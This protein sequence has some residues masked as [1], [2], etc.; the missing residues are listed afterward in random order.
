MTAPVVHHVVD[1]KALR[2]RLRMSRPR[3]AARFGLSVGTLRQWELG[4][5]TPDGAARALLTAISRSPETVDMLLDDRQ[6]A[7]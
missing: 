2:Q 3:F 5:R 6:Q 4:R 1:V 7:G